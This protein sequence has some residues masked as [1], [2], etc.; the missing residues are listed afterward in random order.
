MRTL[1]ELHEEAQ[2]CLNNYYLDIEASNKHKDVDPRP[3]WE[4]LMRKHWDKQAKEYAQTAQNS[5]NLYF[6]MLDQ[7][8]E[9]SKTL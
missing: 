6:L 1:I 3:Y 9:L 4:D 8:N 5:K 2:E 7:I